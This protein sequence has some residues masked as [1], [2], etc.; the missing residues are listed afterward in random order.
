MGG[1][2]SSQKE[3]SNAMHKTQIHPDRVLFYLLLKAMC[4]GFI[5]AIADLAIQETLYGRRVYLPSKY[6]NKDGFAVVLEWIKT[7]PKKV[8]YDARKIVLNALSE[9]YPCSDIPAK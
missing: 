9:A 6:K 4:S 8:K 1:L 7:H 5:T 2:F 3:S